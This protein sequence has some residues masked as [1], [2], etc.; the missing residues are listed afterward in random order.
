MEILKRY[1]RWT[2]LGLALLLSPAVVVFAAPLGCGIIGDLLATAW[3]APVS[4]TLAAIIALNAARR[5]SF[6]AAM[7]K[8]IT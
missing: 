2:T 4:L 6:Q 3:L 5:G 7:P 8:S 1:A